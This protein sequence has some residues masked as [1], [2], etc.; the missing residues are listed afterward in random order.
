LEWGLGHKSARRTSKGNG[1]DFCVHIEFLLL[2]STEFWG[3]QSEI[4][5]KIKACKLF[6][7]Q[8][9][10]SYEGWKGDADAIAKVSVLRDISRA[11]AYSEAVTV[12][13]ECTGTRQEQ[14]DW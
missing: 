3:F 4:Q 5:L 13:V 9:L 7:A 6:G 2:R 8:K 14:G 1:Y 12:C 10:D 11:Y